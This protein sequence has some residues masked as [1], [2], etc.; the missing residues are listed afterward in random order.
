MK[1]F[2]TRLGYG[3]TAVVTGDMTQTDLPRGAK[4]GLR[5][6]REIL[7]NVPGISFCEFTDIDVVRHPLVQKIVLAYEAHDQAEELRR[8]RDRDPRDL[9]SFDAER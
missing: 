4:S 9:S 2:L 5:Q 6:A 7:A 8:Q 1:M 3:T